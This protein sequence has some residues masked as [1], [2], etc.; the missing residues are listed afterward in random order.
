MEVTKAFPSI[1]T[2]YDC[3]AINIQELKSRA[4]RQVDTLSVFGPNRP[5][6]RFRFSDMPANRMSAAFTRRQGPAENALTVHHIITSSQTNEM[7]ETVSESGSEQT[8]KVLTS[9]GAG[10]VV[11]SEKRSSS[12]TSEITENQTSS[13]GTSNVV[14]VK[15]GNPS[16]ANAILVNRQQR[17]VPMNANLQTAPRNV[18]V[19]NRRRVIVPVNA[20]IQASPGQRNVVYVNNVPRGQNVVHSAFRPNIPLTARNIDPYNVN[21]NVN[22]LSA[23]DTE[24]RPTVN[25][26]VLDLTVNVGKVKPGLKLV[27][28]DRRRSGEIQVLDIRK[29]GGVTNVNSGLDQIPATAIDPNYVN[30]NV[31]VL[32]AVNTEGRPTVNPQMLDLTV[33]AGKVNAKPGLNLVPTNHR[34]SG[35]V[36][37]LDLRKTGGVT[38][39]NTGLDQIPAAANSNLYIVSD[40]QANEVKRRRLS[41]PVGS[42][43]NSNVVIASRA[44]PQDST[45]AASSNVHVQSPR[46]MPTILPTPIRTHGIVNIQSE[47]NNQA[48]ASAEPILEI[49]MRRAESNNIGGSQ[50]RVT[51]GGDTLGTSSSISVQDTRNTAVSG[52]TLGSELE[53]N[54]QTN[55]NVRLQPD[56][57]NS[58]K[59]NGIQPL[60][61]VASLRDRTLDLSNVVVGHTQRRNLDLSNVVI[62]QDTPE[63]LS[64]T[65]RIKAGERDTN[66]AMVKKD[67][68]QLPGVINA[69]NVVQTQVQTGLAD[70]NLMKEDVMSDK[71]TI[72]TD[73]SRMITILSAEQQAINTRPASVS[74]VNMLETSREAVNQI[75]GVRPLGNQ[76]APTV[77]S[78]PFVTSWVSR[79]GFRNSASGGIVHSEPTVNSNIITVSR[80]NVSANFNIASGKL[81]ETNVSRI[82]AVNTTTSPDVSNIVSTPIPL[83]W[84]ANGTYYYNSSYYT[85]D[86]N[87]T[88]GENYTNYYNGTMYPNYASMYA[89]MYG[90]ETMYGNYSY[91]NETLYPGNLTMLGNETEYYW[92]MT[93]PTLTNVTVQNVSTT[94]TSVEIGALNTNRTP[95]VATAT[96]KIPVITPAIVMSTIN[97]TTTNLQMTTLKYSNIDFKNLSPGKVSYLPDYKNNL[98]NFGGVAIL[99]G[100]ETIVN[101]VTPGTGVTAIT[102]ERTVNVNDRKDNSLRDGT[103]SIARN[104]PDVNLDNNVVP[105]I[106]P[107]PPVVENVVN[108]PRIVVSYPLDS[109]SVAIGQNRDRNTMTGDRSVQREGA[110]VEVVQGPGQGVEYYTLI[111]DIIKE[112]KILTG[113]FS[114]ENNAGMPPKYDTDINTVVVGM[115]LENK[116]PENIIGTPVRRQPNIAGG[117]IITDIA[118][119]VRDERRLDTG[120]IQVDLEMP[121]IV[122]PST[123]EQETGTGTGISQSIDQLNGFPFVSVARQNTDRRINSII[124]E[125][126][127]PPD[128]PPIS[129]SS[130]NQ[131][132]SKKYTGYELI[133]LVNNNRNTKATFDFFDRNILDNNAMLAAENSAN[134]GVSVRN[135]QNVNPVEEIN[136]MYYFNKTRRTEAE[137][138]TIWENRGMVN[139]ADSTSYNGRFT[140]PGS[141]SKINFR[142][143]PSIRPKSTVTRVDDTG[144]RIDTQKPNTNIKDSTISPIPGMLDLPDV[145][146]VTSQAGNSI[147]QND[148]MLSPAEITPEYIA[149][150]NHD[151]Q[152]I[153]DELM[154]AIKQT[155]NPIA[156]T[157]TPVIKTTD[158]A[159]RNEIIL[160]NTLNKTMSNSETSLTAGN[161][162]S[163]DA[164]IMA[165][166]LHNTMSPDAQ[167]NTSLPQNT[168][169]TYIGSVLSNAQMEDISHK[170]LQTLQTIVKELQLS[171]ELAIARHSLLSKQSLTSTSGESNNVK[172]AVDPVRLNSDMRGN[173]FDLARSVPAIERK[174]GNVKTLAQNLDAIHKRLNGHIGMAESNTVW[175]VHPSLLSV[176]DSRN[177]RGALL[178]RNVDQTGRFQTENLVSTEDARPWGSNKE[179]NGVLGSLFGLSSNLTATS[180]NLLSNNRPLDSPLQNGLD[181]SSGNSQFLLD[182][183][184]RDST[185]FGSNDQASLQTTNNIGSSIADV[186][187]TLFGIGNLNAQNITTS[188]FYAPGTTDQPTNMNELYLQNQLYDLTGVTEQQ[189]DQIMRSLNNAYT[190]TEMSNPGNAAPFNSDPLVYVCP[191]GET[192]SCKAVGSYNGIPGMEWWCFNHCKNGPGSCPKTKCQCTCNPQNTEIAQNVGNMLFEPYVNPKE[193]TGN[194]TN[195]T[196][197]DKEKSVPRKKIWK[198]VIT[199]TLNGSKENA[200]QVNDKG[201]EIMVSR[202]PQILTDT[203]APDMTYSASANGGRRAE[204]KNKNIGIMTENLTSNRKSQ[205]NVIDNRLVCRGKGKFENIE[206]IIDWCTTMCRQAMCPEFVCTCWL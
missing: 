166:V 28:T 111:N 145:Q 77:N 22:V 206:G 121:P 23:V 138:K 202:A 54:Q 60:S 151:I 25:P 142:G 114:K 181:V 61:D 119:T 18:I 190:N 68:Q 82:D 115:G 157:E 10:N 41:G 89:S 56:L 137:V 180:D 26:P 98:D 165:S 109:N 147:K 148:G 86:G 170:I 195:P 106:I 140:Y 67:E 125:S 191:N 188:E 30:A 163:A 100:R 40:K 45:I 4:R 173:R 16:S 92:N 79:T 20:N 141:D 37:V 116:K 12:K 83:E 15:N 87:Y 17:V 179:N 155:T 105:I 117:R 129:I 102:D 11:G 80:E 186:Y 178:G 57:S 172:T 112:L 95:T 91:Y 29:T 32:S 162:S 108:R 14:L 110:R 185:S 88:T 143:L 21:T 96:N 139:G 118:P 199:L 168:P 189:K 73:K 107:K 205:L 193:N 101:S 104:T 76:V 55:S 135:R 58:D 84:N 136:P 63:I 33:N 123:A 64:N 65:V 122:I 161:V 203:N 164:E 134:A 42:F 177:Q 169:T 99:S 156:N 8:V 78:G 31:N 187:K 46:E 146:P 59:S 85:E 36:Q 198:K 1:K 200:V 133:N 167:I 152:I 43:K 2:V 70:S 149:S 48:I 3:A 49:D 24:G 93:E 62:K 171:R 176:G 159:I 19:N 13:G 72:D 128:M 9:S 69:I 6:T 103:T 44:A 183:T 50:N 194:A 160:S 201:P 174:I 204:R 184:I 124:N 132:K 71:K 126:T 51:L 97:P 130:K 120:P 94:T 47:A 197:G 5:R 34:R 53:R 52:P 127:A 74:A 131:L 35:E 27:P 153:N 182:N 158:T 150:I 7:T 39:L 81:P 90:N 66:L 144:S 175:Q 154:K 196:A 38:N 75:S 113:T 192:F